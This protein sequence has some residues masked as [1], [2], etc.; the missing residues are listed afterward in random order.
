MSVAANPAD[1]EAAA[2][3]I[4][5][6]DAPA[7]AKQPIAGDDPAAVRF[8]G[9]TVSLGGVSILEGVTARVPPGSSTA[10]VGP[11][12]AGKTTL[13]L[14]LLG[15]RPYR[16]TIQTR[17]A[18][19]RRPRIGFVPQRLDFDRDLPIT[20]AEFLALDRQRLPLWFGVR[21]AVRERVKDHLR[22][23]QAEGLADR[24]LG[25]LSG[26]ETQRVLLANA[27]AREPDLLVLDEPAAGVDLRGEHLFCE[28]LE[29]LRGER[30]FTQLMVSHDLATVTHHATHVICLNRAVIAEGP[31]RAVLTPEVLTAMFGLHMGL[32]DSRGMPDGSASCSAP[33]CTQIDETGSDGAEGAAPLA[34]PREGGGD[35]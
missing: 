18:D 11:N 19:G 28:I 15:R 8:D 35:A 21:R 6:A 24:R 4:A 34:R 30:G 17:R 2:R 26:G 7:Q 33:C 31:P 29:R 12:G 16:G 3:S 13:L 25:A 5:D 1:P 9:V 23:V 27:L 20:V 14:A 22:E 32:V 10:I